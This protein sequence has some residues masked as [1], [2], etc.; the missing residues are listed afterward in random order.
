MSLQTSPPLLQRDAALAKVKQQAASLAEAMAYA[1]AMEMRHANEIER[2]T[3][4]HQ[5]TELNI[6]EIYESELKA[7]RNFAFS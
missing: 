1:E 6:Q 5:Q 7:V 3:Q 2:L 4:Q